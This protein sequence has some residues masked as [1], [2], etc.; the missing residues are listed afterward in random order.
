MVNPCRVQNDKYYY[1][2]R[3]EVMTDP[4]LED[5]P[6]IKTCLISNWQKLLSLM[7][8]NKKNMDN[9]VYQS[10]LFKYI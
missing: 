9:K 7:A 1:D 5:V 4:I 3:N 2:L 10:D 8:S 6:S